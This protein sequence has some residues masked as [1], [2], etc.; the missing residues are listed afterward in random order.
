M[1]DFKLAVE[2]RRRLLQMVINIPLVF[3][4]SCVE[5]IRTRAE[6]YLQRS[7]RALSPTVSLTTPHHREKRERER[8][9]E[10]ERQ[11]RFTLYLPRPSLPLVV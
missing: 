8:E 7:C 11:P 5:W 2:P 1:S 10:R 3:V 4:V 9:R 6:L